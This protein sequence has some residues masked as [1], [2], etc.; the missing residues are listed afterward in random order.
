V[1]KPDKKHKIVAQFGFAGPLYFAKFARLN[2]SLKKQQK[3][4][5]AGL[6]LKN[7]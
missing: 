2:D 4:C 1:A 3:G 7:L 5:R 6:S